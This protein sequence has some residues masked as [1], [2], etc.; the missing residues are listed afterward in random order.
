MRLEVTKR[1][2]REAKRLAG[3]WL[4][5]RDKAPELFEEELLA[6]YGVIQSE[7]ALGQTYAASRGRRIQRV[8][9]PRTKNHVAYHQKSTDVVQVIAIWGAI[10]G[11]GP[12]L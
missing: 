5:H 8:L 6:A 2:Q 4:E 9:M 1:A 10:R 3:G 7:P 12:N 11:R